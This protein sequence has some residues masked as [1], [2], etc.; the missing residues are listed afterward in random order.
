MAP[1]TRHTSSHEE[2]FACCYQE[3]RT[4]RVRRLCGRTVLAA[5]AYG[6]CSLEV[7]EVGCGG[8]FLAGGDSKDAL[9]RR[10]NTFKLIPRVTKGSWII[11]Q[12]VGTT[13]CL[14]GNKLT[15]KYYQ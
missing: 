12:S 7:T 2:R 15:T 9:A 3:R 1:R 14:L 4:L 8:R 13:P 5:A 11:K 10:N 6:S